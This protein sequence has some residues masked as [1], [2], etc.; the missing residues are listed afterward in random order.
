MICALAQ[1]LWGSGCAAGKRRYPLSTWA[2]CFAQYFVFQNPLRSPSCPSTPPPTREFDLHS[3]HWS[4][5]WLG[6]CVPWSWIPCDSL[7]SALKLP[8]SCYIISPSPFAIFLLFMHWWAGN[9]LYWSSFLRKHCLLGFVLIEWICED[10][11]FRSRLIV[12]YISF[13]LQ[14]CHAILFRSEFHVCCSL[15]KQWLWDAC[16][17]SYWKKCFIFLKVVILCLKLYIF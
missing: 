7:S 5:N 2:E 9:V 1:S 3:A 16:F 10:Q 14:Y 11:G 15:L 17:V 13:Q 8:H 4:W 6:L 12:S